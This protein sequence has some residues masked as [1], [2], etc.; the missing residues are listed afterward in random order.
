MRYETVKILEEN[1]VLNLLQ[2]MSP[3]ARENKN[4]NKLLGLHQNKKLLLSEGNN[5]RNLSQPME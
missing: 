3:E 1:T 4:K 2:S 5:Q